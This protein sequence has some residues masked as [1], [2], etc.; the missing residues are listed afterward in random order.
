MT[1]AEI[2]GCIFLMSQLW[3]NY[4]PPSTEMEINAL[5]NTW[6]KFFGNLS[7]NEVTGAIM[8]ISAEGGEFAPQI[9]QIYARVKQKRQAALE[10]RKF[11]EEYYRNCLALSKILDIEP[12]SRH[13]NSQELVNWFE[14][15]RS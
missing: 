15:A 3:S 5:T 10:C 11:S 6:V 12:P 7:G 13:C 1:P 14:N 8:E 9:G 2:K 4:K